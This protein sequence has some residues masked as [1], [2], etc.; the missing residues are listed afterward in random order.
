MSSTLSFY[1]DSP[2]SCSYLA[3]EQAQNIYPDPNWPMSNVLYSQLIQ[4][5]FR[6]SGDHA[7]RPHCPNC[8]ACVPVRININQFL[9]SRSQRR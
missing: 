8:Q 1:Q 3:T 5:G 9:A 2:H 6:R 7:Y 4:H